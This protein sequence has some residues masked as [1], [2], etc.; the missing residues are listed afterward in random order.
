MYKRQALSY[1]CLKYSI[2]KEDLNEMLSKGAKIVTSTK[3]EQAVRYTTT[4]YNQYS[5][6]N[7]QREND[8]SCLGISYIVEGKKSLLNKYSPRK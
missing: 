2:R 7:Y 3:W 8:G 1:E 5:D 4:L 6:E